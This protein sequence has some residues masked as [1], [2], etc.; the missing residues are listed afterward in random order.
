MVKETKTKSKKKW[1][2]AG[3]LIAVLLVAVVIVWN[4]T[5]PSSVATSTWQPIE[6]T[7]ANLP[8]YLSQFQPVNELPEDSQIA[9]IVGNSEYV[10]TKGSVA[11]GKASNPE[12]TVSL[13]E[14]Y[15]DI[16]GQKGWCAGVQEA[17]RNGELGVS[18]NGSP[19]S[20]GWKYRALL[21]YR[22]CIG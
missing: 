3:V 13:P 14:K 5:R 18:F 8:S 4:I 20:L 7:S 22:L 9:L 10:V 2:I 17:Q 21:K 1:I 6:L 15:F 12:I 16:V 19:A 11:L